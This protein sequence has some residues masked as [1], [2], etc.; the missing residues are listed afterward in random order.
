MAIPAGI[1]HNLLG[2][3]FLAAALMAGVATAAPADLFVSSV[4]FNTVVQ[5]D[6]NTGAFLNVFASDALSGPRGV[7]FGRDGNLY[8]ANNGTSSVTRYDPTGTIIDIFVTSAGELRGPRCI[9]FDAAGNLYVGSRSTNSVVRYDA[10]GQHITRD[11]GDPFIPPGGG[12]LS[13]PRGLVFGP[14][15]NL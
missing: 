5:Y 9:I 7:L 10:T 13:G 4:D 11:N 3:G 2:V 15:G 8:V 14:V 12:G 6:E 1:R